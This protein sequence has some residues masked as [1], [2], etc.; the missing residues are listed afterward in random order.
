MPRVSDMFSVD[1]DQSGGHSVSYLAPL[2]SA[3][4][5]ALR[6]GYVV[7]EMRHPRDLTYAPLEG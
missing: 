1:G 5:D 7:V 2:Y 4:P 3:G 6:N